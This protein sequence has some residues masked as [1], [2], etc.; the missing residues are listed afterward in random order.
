MHTSDRDDAVPTRTPTFITNDEREA[1]L[2][3]NQVVEPADVGIGRIL[4]RAG[5][6][7]VLAA[8]AASRLPD[9]EPDAGRRKRL[10]DRCGGLR[11][12]L[13]P[14]QVEASLAAGRAAGARFVVPGDAQWPCALDD[15]DELAPIGLWIVGALPARGA[16]AGG[17]VVGAVSV[18]GARA[19]TGYGAHVAGTL[20]ADLARAGVPVVSGAAFGID[21]AAH[22]GALAV[23]GVTVAVLACGIDQVYPRSHD[24]LLAAVKER[25]AV[26]SE[27]PPRSRPTRFRFLHRN[28]LI[29]A[30]GVG[31]VVVEA[32]DRS[33][34][35]VT[36]RLANDLGRAVMAVPGPVTSE[37]SSGVHHLIR[38]G[39]TMVTGARDVLEVCCG[40]PADSR[41]HWPDVPEPRDRHQGAAAGSSNPELSNPELSNPAPSNPAPSN[42]APSN[43]APSNPELPDPEP[44]DPE[45][46]DPLAGLVLE[47]LPLARAASGADV[48]ALARATGF[49]PEQVLAVLGR[50]A[51]TGRAVR[52]GVGW[53]LAAPP[54]APPP[55][56][57]RHPAARASPPCPARPAARRG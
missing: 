16:G 52:T 45:P 12:R 56:A 32:A 54:P 39:A 36:A 1:R 43:P 40:S 15:L 2:L 38:D 44:S 29:A 14:D 41:S 47:A 49:A 17:S 31:T 24:L 10:A 46:S 33:G 42:P 4:R 19:C 5:P 25:G 26:V 55:A 28:R 27:L 23:D 3:L 13:D 11:L 30:M 7:E 8:V 50:L 37:L 57:A 48:L 9:L 18:V 20:S 22:R 6:V 34:S 53:Q 35:L 21:A 51:A